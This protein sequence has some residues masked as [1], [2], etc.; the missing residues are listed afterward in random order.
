MH[1]AAWTDVDGAEADPEGAAR[2][3][4]DGS[5]LVARAARAGG[6]T[7]VAFST[8]YV[9]AGDDP[10]G[11]DETDP[12]DPRSVYGATKLAGERAMQDGAA[13]GL[14]GAHRLG[15]RAARP[16]LRAHDAAP[17]RRARG[18]ERR[19][20]PARLPDLHAPPRRGDR[21]TDRVLPA[22][23][24]PPR[25]RRRLHLARARRGHHGGGRPAGPRR[26]RSPAP[27]WTA[28]RR[29]PPA[30]SCAASTPA[31]RACRTGAT[32]CAT[33][34]TALRH[35]EA[36]HE[37]GS[38]SPAAAA[39][40][41]RTSCAACS[42]RHDGVEVVNLDALT[43]AGNPA[44]LAD[45]ADDPRYRFVHGSIATPTPSP[46]R[47][48][49]AMR[50]STSPP[51][52]TSTARSSRPATSSRPTSSAPT[53]CSSGSGTTAA[54]SCTSRPTRSTATS[55]RATPR[56]RTTRCARPRR[57]RPPRPAATC[58]CVAYVRTYGVDAVHHA[59]LE[60]LRAEPVPREADPAL[61]HEPAR[62]RAGAGLRRR[63]PGA[64]LHLRRGSLRGHRDGAR[65][66]RH[67]ARSTTSAAATRSRT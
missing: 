4:E 39:S 57:T 59:R 58:R 13:R 16:Q 2:V 45:V 35:A 55:R 10:A 24:V 52:R 22:G 27:S 37:D 6:A 65:A 20:R 15:V 36:T 11:Y 21:A 66:R 43:Y 40:S 28:R 26:C 19:R 46:R 14:R 63:P 17:R 64:R 42:Q 47:P 60:Q 48:R 18:A 51:R 49:A 38:S 29:D 3:N 32:G 34:S 5:R 12:V 61:H 53:C 33:A 23:H 7:L 1:C 54:A 62:R 67:A 31:P 8:D 44:N 50:S 41:A 30:R 25:R 56:A 9:F